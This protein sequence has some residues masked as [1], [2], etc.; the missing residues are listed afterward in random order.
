MVLESIIILYL[1]NDNDDDDDDNDN[2]DNNNN[3]L[4]YCTFVLKMIKLQTLLSC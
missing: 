1:F 3:L 2:N 4:T